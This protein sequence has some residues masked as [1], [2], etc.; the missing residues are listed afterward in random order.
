MAML[1]HWSNFILLQPANGLLGFDAAKGAQAVNMKIAINK[2]PIL[3][4]I[5]DL[6]WLVIDSVNLIEK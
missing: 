6:L 1:N 3:F 5:F 2:A 4:F